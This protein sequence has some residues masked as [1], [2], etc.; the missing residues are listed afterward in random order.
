MWLEHYFTVWKIRLSFS[1]LFIFNTLQFIA[2][3]YGY[4]MHFFFLSNFT[5]G[6]S[7]RKFYRSTDDELTES[8]PIIC[9]YPLGCTATAPL[10]T[11]PPYHRLPHKSRSDSGCSN[12][13]RGWPCQGPK[14]IDHILHLT[15]IIMT[16]NG[17]TIIFIIPRPSQSS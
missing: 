3:L 15:T 12:S 2:I 10:S 14:C 8:P 7:I 16:N 9:V 11:L 1:P 17:Y 13:Y 4:Y 5:H 6:W